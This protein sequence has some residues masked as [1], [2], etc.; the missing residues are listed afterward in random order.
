MFEIDHLSY[1]SLSQYLLCSHA[2]KLRYID[3]VPTPTAPALVFGSAFHKTLEAHLKTGE[4][5]TSLWPQ[6]WLTQLEREQNIDWSNEHAPELDATGE[7][8]MMA[9]DVQELV[10][11]IAANFDGEPTNLE[12][13]V[14]LAVPGVPVPIIGYIDI[15]TRDGVPGDFKTSSRMWTQTQ[16]EAEI[17]P[18]F[19]LAALNQAGISVPDLRFRHYIFTKGRHPAAKAFETTHTASQLVWLFELIKS[20]WQAIEAGV[21][22]MSGVGS[23]KCAP[24]YCEYYTH[25]RGRYD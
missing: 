24:R 19:Y 9:G 21:Y 7:R 25:C 4:Q 3:K 23:W 2:W 11:E 18:L 10:A 8:M 20:A 6:M 1:S 16:A 15:V 12:R 17:Q 5:L 13:Y 22:P 14:E